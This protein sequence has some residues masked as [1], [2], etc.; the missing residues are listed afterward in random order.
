MIPDFKTFIK[1]SIWADIYDRSTGET[2]RKEDNPYIDRDINSLSGEEFCDYLTYRYEVLESDIM[3]DTYSR[4]ISVPLYLF[5]GYSHLS[6]T[7]SDKNKNKIV[8]VSIVNL[9]PI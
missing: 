6:I 9:T 7:Y 3:Y 1:E 4:M 2:E 5:I 8:E